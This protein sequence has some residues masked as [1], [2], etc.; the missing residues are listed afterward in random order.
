MKAAWSGQD[1]KIHLIASA[2]FAPMVLLVAISGG[3]YL[4][5]AKGQFAVTN[6]ELP[7]GASGVA[8]VRT[9]GG[10]SMRNSSSS[11][12]RERDDGGG[13]SWVSMSERVGR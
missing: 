3:L 10:R 13:A 1:V 7:A 11:T 12:G 6:L 9:S 8:P 4:L 2:F 5:G